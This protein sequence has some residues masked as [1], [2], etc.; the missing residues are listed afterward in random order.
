LIPVSHYIRFGLGTVDLDML[1]TYWCMEAETRTFGIKYSGNP[2]TSMFV[3]YKCK[4][5][6][7]YFYKQL[8]FCKQMRQILS[9]KGPAKINIRS[10]T[11]ASAN[12]MYHDQSD[13]NPLII[14]SKEVDE[15]S[16]H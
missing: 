9:A 7:S 10:A 1:Y 12:W 14:S 6:N 15:L 11:P 8:P 4:N 16:K 5:I 3:V 13:A 2:R